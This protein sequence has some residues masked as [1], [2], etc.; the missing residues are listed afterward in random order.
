M[1]KMP[2]P[3]ALAEPEKRTVLQPD[4]I[5]ARVLPTLNPRFARFSEDMSRRARFGG[6]TVEVEPR[7]RAILNLIHDVA[8]VGRPPDAD[9]EEIRVLG[10]VDPAEE[11]G[12][13]RK[14]SYPHRRI[15]VA[16]LRIIPALD[17]RMVRNVID[18]RVLGD[19]PFVELQERHAGRIGA[20]PVGAMVAT[21]VQL[22]GIH[23]VERAVQQLRAAIR[24]ERSLSGGGCARDENIV[25]LDERH[26]AAV[27]AERRLRF[28]A[29][30]FRQPGRCLRRDS[31]GEQVVANRDE[32]GV[33]R[34]IED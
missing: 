21:A 11:S 7:L 14:D 5:D 26:A 12:G 27:G 16:S 10:G 24:R 2:P 13:G 6:G 28:G 33:A 18:Q 34:W 25:V 22:F 1:E 31:V 20:P 4:R 29:G 8:A 3:A 9:D 15:R 23:P 17:V 32:K 30:R 19:R